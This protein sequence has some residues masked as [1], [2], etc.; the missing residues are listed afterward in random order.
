MIRLPHAI[1]ARMASQ[2]YQ[3]AF[4][5]RG[6]KEAYVLP[7]ELLDILMGK[8]RNATFTRMIH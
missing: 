3:E 8:L 1:L 4:I 7:E 6:T 2:A 5:D